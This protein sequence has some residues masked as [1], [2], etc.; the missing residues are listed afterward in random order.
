MTEWIDL[1]VSTSVSQSSRY[2]V[3]HLWLYQQSTQS[4]L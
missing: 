4:Y 2:D 1:F 3:P